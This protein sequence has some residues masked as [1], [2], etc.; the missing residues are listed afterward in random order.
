MTDEEKEKYDR[1]V[2]D[3]LAKTRCDRCHAPIENTKIMSIFNTDR[4][5]YDCWKKEKQAPN[6]AKA[7]A[8]ERTAIENGDWFFWGSIKMAYRKARPSVPL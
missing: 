2:R 6:Y 8:A 4:L 1:I 3:F 5:C 7:V